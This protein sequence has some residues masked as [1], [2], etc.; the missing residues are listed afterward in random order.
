[1]CL[2]EDLL[3][4]VRC[5]ANVHID[6]KIY[7][8]VALPWWNSWGFEH[9]LRTSII[10][11][12]NDNKLFSMSSASRIPNLTIQLLETA[13]LN[14]RNRASVSKYF[15]PQQACS[16]R[17][18]VPMITK[19]RLKLPD[20]PLSQASLKIVWVMCVY[21]QLFNCKMDFKKKLTSCMKKPILIHQH[22]NARTGCYRTYTRQQSTASIS[23]ESTLNACEMWQRAVMMK[24]E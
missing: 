6:T 2:W 5:W 15:G 9:I 3:A 4:L 1:M 19:W 11:K 16:T 8:C 17:Y 24:G 18:I 14:W 10:H 23:K 21:G 20:L 7:I 13:L 22:R 12:Q